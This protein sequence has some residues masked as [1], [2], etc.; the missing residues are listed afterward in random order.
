[1]WSLTY[2]KAYLSAITVTN[3]SKCFYL[4][5]G[6]KNQLTWIWNKIMS[7]SPNVYMCVYNVFHI[8]QHC[9]QLIACNTRCC[10]LMHAIARCW[11]CLGLQEGSCQ[12]GK[13]LSKSYLLTYFHCP[14]AVLL[15]IHTTHVRGAEYCDERVCLSVFSLQIRSSPIFACYL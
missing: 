14:L 2:N 3:I 13:T 9:T 5:D 12:A 8:S 4:Q 6:G 15:S 11:Q 7:P 10:L 1:M